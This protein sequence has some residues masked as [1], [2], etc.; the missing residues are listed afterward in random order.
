VSALR[1]IATEGLWRRNVVFAQMLSLC[2]LMAVTDTATNGL[3]MGI[4]ATA[5][6]AASGLTVSFWRVFVA[7]EIRLPALVMIFATLVTLLDLSMN[8]WLHP[9]HKSLGLFIPLIVVNCAILGRAEA[10]ASRA[11]LG[12]ALLDGLSTGLG[13]LFALTLLGAIRETLGSGTLFANA[14]LLLGKPFA[15]LELRLIPEYRGFLLFI[16][17]PGGF[18]VV[19]FLIAAKRRIDARAV[20][21]PAAASAPQP[22]EQT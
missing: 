19:G 16:L 10:F 2:P 3:G 13:F 12:P 7:T 17:P 11:P 21:A 8:A 9:L 5:V 15:F 4:A 14:S 20:P 18:L 1:Q 6:L 22:Q